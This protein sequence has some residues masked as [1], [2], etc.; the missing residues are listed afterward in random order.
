MRIDIITRRAPHDADV[1]LWLGP[2]V[3]AD[4]TLCLNEP[5]LSERSLHRPC[6]EQ[7][8]RPV[9]AVLRLLDEQQPIE[10]LDRVVLIEEAVVNQPRVLVTRPAMQA[11]TLRLLHGI[12]GR[13]CETGML[14]PGAASGVTRAEASSTSLRA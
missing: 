8:G 5:A 12:Q 7:H 6:H 2:V 14:D 4:R 13:S 10:Q 11:R 1:R 3:E 9:P